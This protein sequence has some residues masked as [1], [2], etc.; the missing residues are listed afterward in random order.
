MIRALLPAIKRIGHG[1]IIIIGSEA[2][3]SGGRKGAI[4]CASKF[5]LRGFA[6]ALREECARNRIRV[7]MINPGM[8]KTGFFNE[9]DFAPGDSEENYILPEDIADAAALVINTRYGTVYD[10]INLSPQ[11]KVI[12]PR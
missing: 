8:V 10:E 5:A 1:D 4:Y 6:Q 12:Q 3:L 7:T 2:A 9:L 11:K